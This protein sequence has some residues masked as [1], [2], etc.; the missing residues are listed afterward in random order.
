[1]QLHQLQPNTKRKSRKR[2]GRGGVH[3]TYSTRGLKGQKARAGARIRPDFEGGRTPLRR[4]VPKMRGAGFRKLWK[5]RPLAIGLSLLSS[6]FNDT[7]V[8][9]PESLFKK[10]LIFSK[11][12]NFKILSNGVIE[13][14]IVVENCSI[15][16]SAQEK[17]IKAGGQV[18]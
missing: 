14:K 9:N 16:K 4:L 18:K 7:E 11:K 10:G 1:M 3:G 6:K 8:I 2:I 13:H 17:I 15:S 5:Q 12:Q